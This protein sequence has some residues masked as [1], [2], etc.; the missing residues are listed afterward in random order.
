ML[1]FSLPML[2]SVSP[3]AA[4]ASTDRYTQISLYLLLLTGVLTLFS[5][6]KVDLVSVIVAA[7]ALAVKGVRWWRGYG[8]ELS[9][10]RATQFVIAYFLFFPLDL[11]FF[12]RGLAVGA[13]NPALYAALLA[14]IHLLLFAIGVR[15][16]S[17]TT[18]RDYLFLSLLALASVLA[19]AIL[20]VD[21]TFIIFLLVFLGLAVSTFI[22]IEMRRSAEGAVSPAAGSGSPSARRLHR[23]LGITSAAVAVFA[24]TLG[25]GIFLLFPRLAAGYFSA[26]NFQPSLISGFSDNV[27]LGQI[28]EIK[29]NF[30]VVMRVKVEGGTLRSGRVRWRGVGFTTFDGKRWFNKRP[31]FAI[32]SSTADGWFSLGEPS[33][34]LRMNSIRMDYRVLLNPLASDALFVS[35]QAVAVRGNFTA[36]TGSGFA[37]ARRNFL[38]L[39]RQT[40]SLSN[41]FHNY[42]NLRYEATSLV[43]AVR[44]QKLRAASTVYASEIRD[45]YLQLPELDPRIRDLARKITA[46]SPTPYDKAAAMESYLQTR[47]AYSLDLS[48]APGENPLSYFLFE[49]RAGHC[50]YFAAAMTV[51]LR[52]LGIPARYVNGF[53]PGEYNDVGE[54][55]IVR[56]SDA[57]SWVEVYF[58]EYGWITF[59]PTPPSLDTAGGRF[60]RLAYYWDW[61]ELTWN[62]WIINYDFAHQATLVQ[63]VRQ[64]SRSWSDRARSLY[65]RWREKSIERVSAWE[66]WAKRSPYL[67]PLAVVAGVALVLLLRGRALAQMLWMLW[68]VRLAPSARVSPGLATMQYEQL[69]RLLGRRGW[70][71][72]PAQTPLEFASALPAAELASPVGEFTR[73]YQEARFGGLPSDPQKMSS[74]LDTIRLLLRSGATKRSS[75][76]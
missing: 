31:D 58:P 18:N 63:N 46:A 12:S 67:V 36:G 28:G 48:G 10:R 25:T 59:D 69:L 30:A 61:F 24:L 74:L 49:R 45:A 68:R 50:E 40:G 11:W 73:L 26:L 3:A 44:P 27:E 7:V 75:P 47:Y 4:S 51:M 32:I 54:D 76:A 20:T 57:H 2:E 22:G 29:K 64:T 33:T 65:S 66:L 71:K 60:K 1:K 72:S 35:S 37:G 41:P 42:S 17:A 13:P 21:T 5:T 9:H 14:A 23:A 56:A 70:K 34:A 6:G 43:P 16:F 38:S 39:D 15:L 62:E 8:P 19:A 52:S 55:Y 53:L